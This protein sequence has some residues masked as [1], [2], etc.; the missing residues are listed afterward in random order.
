MVYDQ[1]V[2]GI[3]FGETAPGRALVHR[4]IDEAVGGAEIEMVGLARNCG[5]SPRV[6]AI[7]T[8]W[9]PRSG[10]AVSNRC[11]REKTDEDEGER[12]ES[13][14]TT[15]DDAQDCP[16]RVTECLR[17]QTFTQHRKRR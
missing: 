2:F 17:V 13:E 14:K 15:G 16:S 4:L 1:V 9:N 8:D 10:S 3:E 11:H 12:G 6:A 7:R 5:Q